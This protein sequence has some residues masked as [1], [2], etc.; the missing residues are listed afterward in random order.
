MKA[1]VAQTCTARRPDQAPNTVTSITAIPYFHWA[2]RGPSAMR[3]W[4]P[5]ASA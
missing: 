1:G 2:N 3:V 5:T 4:I